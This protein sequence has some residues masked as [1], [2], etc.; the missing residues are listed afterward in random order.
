MTELDAS[1]LTRDLVERLKQEAA[2][3]VSLDD[4]VSMCFGWAVGLMAG[5]GF[6]PREIAETAHWL[7]T[8]FEVARKDLQ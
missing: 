3:G 5:R 1:A 2:K 4:C 8:S 6:S 7:A